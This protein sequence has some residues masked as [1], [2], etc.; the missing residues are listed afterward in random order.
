MND[1]NTYRRRDAVIGESLTDECIQW[2]RANINS[3]K[4]KDRDKERLR[5][6]LVRAGEGSD[7]KERHKR[8]SLAITHFFERSDWVA[9]RRKFYAF[10]THQNTA[11]K[12]VNLPQSIWKRLERFK[13]AQGYSNHVESLDHLL[14]QVE[15]NED[16]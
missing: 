3:F 10:R 5:G 6:R 13:I 8:F 7:I 12:Q 14:A 15:D 1:W 16:K 2:A 4:L 11:R 9:I